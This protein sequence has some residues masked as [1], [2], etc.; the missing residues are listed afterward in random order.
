MSS[1]VIFDL[2]DGMIT[3]LK[4]IFLLGICFVLCCVKLREILKGR[5][6]NRQLLFFQSLSDANYTYNGNRCD[7]NTHI[8]PI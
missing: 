3:N 1:W 6:G 7:S 5:S 4:D 8:G 2:F